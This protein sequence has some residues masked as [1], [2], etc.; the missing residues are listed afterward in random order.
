MAPMA[1]VFTKDL[2]R[3]AH[4]EN[5]HHQKAEEFTLSLPVLVFGVGHPNTVGVNTEFGPISGRNSQLLNAS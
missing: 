3:Q 5:T 2:A 1:A 4:S